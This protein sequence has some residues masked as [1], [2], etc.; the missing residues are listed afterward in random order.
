[1]ILA[2]VVAI[3][4]AAVTG[5]VVGTR[6][7]SLDARIRSTDAALAPPPPTAAEIST[8]TREQESRKLIADALRLVCESVGANTALLWQADASADVLH[9]LH[10]HARAL[11][12]PR[13]LRGDPIAWAAR[14]GTPLRIDP[15][16]AWADAAAHVVAQRL[17][18]GSTV[19][20]ADDRAWIV[21]F[22]FDA[23][24]AYNPALLATAVAPLRLLLDLIDQQ[25]STEAVRRRMQ[26]LLGLLHRIP[27]VTELEPAA[28]ELLAASIQ[29][30]D[31]TGGAVALWDGESG[32]IISVAGGDGGPARDGVFTSPTSELALAVRAGIPLIRPQGAWKP[33]ATHIATPEDRW[34]SRVRTFAAIPLSTS[35]GISS[36]LVVWSTREQRLDQ[37]G[38]DLVSAIAPYAALHLQ[39]A[40]QFGQLKMTAETDAL[41]GLRN[42]RAFD[43]ALHL[44]SSRFERYGR[45]IS[46]LMIDV[47]HFKAINDQHGH[48][49]GDHVLRELARVVQ[50]CVRDV[51]TAARFGGEEL[52]VLLPETQRAA[53]AEVA[54][55]IR[56]SVDNLVVSWAGRTVPVTVSVGVASAPERVKEAGRL[57][58]TADEALYTAKKTGRN[59]V[60]TP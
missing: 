34:I 25:S 31:A 48:E 12:A 11:P 19:Q 4:A 47:D 9:A 41:T 28:D 20:H 10:A 36:V 16:P 6:R 42:R 1:M 8:K 52:A 21:T 60:V 54:E 58:A 24:S 7:A 44:E 38:L 14:E 57:L 45:P 51:D 56:H 29:L 5:Y 32:S 22:E 15:S 18:G 35:T 40:R 55:R 13:A 26:L 2:L 17:G 43:S 53:A 46:L 30:T 49:G 27:V 23:Q 50:S 3:I 39:H 59:R 37:G 33:G